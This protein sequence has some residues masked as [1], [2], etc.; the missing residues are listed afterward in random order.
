MQLFIIFGFSSLAKEEKPELFRLKEYFEEKPE[1]F[2]LKEY[3]KLF[4]FSLQKK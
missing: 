3:F 4:S 1:L 2:R